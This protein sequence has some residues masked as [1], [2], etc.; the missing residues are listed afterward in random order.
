MKKRILSV[1]LA[2]SMTVCAFSGCSDN[3]KETSSYRTVEDY[4]V[5]YKIRSDVKEIDDKMWDYSFDNDVNFRIDMDYN[6]KKASSDFAAEVYCDNFD[7]FE[8]VNS[9]IIKCGDYDV[10][11]VSGDGND[12]DRHACY[13]TYKKDYNLSGFQVRL[14]YPKN[15]DEK[16]IREL[17]L[18]IIESAEFYG[19]AE[20]LENRDF[21]CGYFSVSLPDEFFFRAKSENKAV[22]FFDYIDSEVKNKSAFTIEAVIHSEYDSAEEYL[23]SKWDEDCR[24]IEKTEIL[25]YDGYCCTEQGYINKTEYAFEK[26]G[27]IYSISIMVLEGEGQEEVQ[28]EFEKLIDSIIIN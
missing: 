18:E 14:K 19:N 1:F 21:D 23:R 17:A 4:D 3:G 13:I 8:N 24:N 25:G 7:H 28:A 2:L 27:I 6:L 12:S 10:I 22:V 9:E 15:H 26:N 5:S 11:A 20:S 16:Q